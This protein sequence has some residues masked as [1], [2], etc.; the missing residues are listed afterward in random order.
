[1]VEVTGAVL[2]S[3]VNGAGRRRELRLTVEL[4]NGHL[5]P[6][7]LR[8][9]LHTLVREGD[10]VRLIDVRT[11][12]GGVLWP[13]RVVDANSQRVVA[14]SPRSAADLAMG[15][16]VALLA[17]LI[18]FVLVALLTGPSTPSGCR[19]G[20]ERLVGT[21]PGTGAARQ[22]IPQPGGAGVPSTV[23]QAPWVRRC[24]GRRRIPGLRLQ[25]G[26]AA[27]R[28][29]PLSA[30]ALRPAVRRDDPDTR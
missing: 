8:G 9:R 29:P 18:V 27:P 19:P 17:G 1:M 14:V 21:H 16:L 12:P 10:H 3:Q 25:C 28:L 30:V 22:P 23:A 15:L 13:R 7:R 24:S 5:L 26:P 2:R 4:E 6:V 20:W 11:G